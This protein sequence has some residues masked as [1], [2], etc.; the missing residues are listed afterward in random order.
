MKLFQ[1]YPT[2]IYDGIL[3]TNIM[4]RAKIRDAIKS[5]SFVYYQ[6]QVTD[7]DRPDILATKYYG[8]PTYT[9]AIF[10]ANDIYDPL[11]EW[12]LTTNQFNNY[13]AEKYGSIQIAM[14][15]PHHYLLNNQ[16]VI[17]KTTY[18]D[19]NVPENTKSI[20]TNYDYESE[21]NESKRNIKIIDSLYITQLVNE[22]S[23]IFQS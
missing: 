2:I 9:W 1:Y 12:P 13:V 6:Y 15:T 18:D 5:D 21:L 10:Y 14:I 4:V 22:M 23:Q 7:S 20:V 3:A 16:Y 19:V 17:D 11:T 8:N